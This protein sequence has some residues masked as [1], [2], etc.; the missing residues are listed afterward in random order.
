M[1][2]E[3]VLYEKR[4]PQ[5]SY[6]LREQKTGKTKKFP[7]GKNVQKAIEA[8]L[9]DF[10]G[11]REDTIHVKKRGKYAHYAATSLADNQPGRTKRG[12]L[13]K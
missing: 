1:K 9:S 2:V 3:D 5:S 8:F 6:E 12:S 13:A 7:L 4:K 11:N 10:Q